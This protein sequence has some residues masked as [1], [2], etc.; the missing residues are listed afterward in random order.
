MKPLSLRAA[1]IDMLPFEWGQGAVHQN[2]AHATMHD[3]V[4]AA[5]ADAVLSS[6]GKERE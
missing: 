3:V 6:M 4:F 5:V 1:F 2:G